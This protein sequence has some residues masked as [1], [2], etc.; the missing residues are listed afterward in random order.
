[1]WMS[2]TRVVDQ[3]HARRVH[4]S[5]VLLAPAGDP[6]VA[7]PLKVTDETVVPTSFLR[8]IPPAPRRCGDKWTPGVRGDM[9]PSMRSAIKG[10]HQN[11]LARRRRASR[12]CSR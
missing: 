6:G 4:A 8:R 12:P 7:C 10:S 5:L 9:R 3:D 1:R 11:I 2:E